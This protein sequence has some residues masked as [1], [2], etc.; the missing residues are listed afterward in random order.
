MVTGWKEKKLGDIANVRMCK[1]IFAEQTT[2]T[3]EIPFYKIGTFGKESN[4]Y[5]P[6]ELF[7]EYRSKYSYPKIGEVL[8]SASGTIGRTVI[9]NGQ[10]AYFQDSNIVWI[11]NDE[12]QVLNKYLFY[13]YKQLIIEVSGYIKLFNRDSFQRG[14]EIFRTV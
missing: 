4:A 10:D 11:E 9:F 13:S 7:D 12:T 6:R 1:R 2:S 5:I 14:I 3:G 8:I